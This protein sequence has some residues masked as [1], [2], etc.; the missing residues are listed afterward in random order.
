MRE[1]SERKEGT[2]TLVEKYREKGKPKGLKKDDQ[3]RK[4]RSNS[5]F[6]LVILIVK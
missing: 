3:G 4:E 6:L 1:K 5:K 2:K